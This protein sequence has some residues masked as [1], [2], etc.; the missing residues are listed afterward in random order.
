MC[1]KNL[2]IKTDRNWCLQQKLSVEQMLFNDKSLG[3]NLLSPIFISNFWMYS[4]LRLDLPLL[5]SRLS[6][7]YNAK[8]KQIA[9]GKS[10]TSSMTTMPSTTKLM[11]IT[12]YCHKL[13]ATIVVVIIH[14][15][16]TTA[17]I[18]KAY[19]Q[20]IVVSRRAEKFSASR[21]TAKKFMA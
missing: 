15:H 5:Y 16:Q 1:A 9:V 8:N 17:D 6:T 14:L 20:A 7:H 4:K 3:V 19:T 11:Q 10:E 18:T 13:S 2:L 21:K 12:S